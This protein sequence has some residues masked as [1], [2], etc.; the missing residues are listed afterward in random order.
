MIILFATI[1]IEIYSVGHERECSFDGMAKKITFYFI[2]QE[3]LRN[4][5]EMIDFL[6]EA[7][8]LYSH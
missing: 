6:P 7:H 3:V 8:N 5:T 4:I 1:P 2:V